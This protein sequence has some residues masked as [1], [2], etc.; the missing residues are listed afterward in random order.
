MCG[1]HVHTNKP[2]GMK[3]M[4]VGNVNGKQRRKFEK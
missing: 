4:D 2:S 3:N 1:R